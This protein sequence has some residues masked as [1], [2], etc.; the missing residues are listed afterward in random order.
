MDAFCAELVAHPRA[1]HAAMRL[2]GVYRFVVEP[3]GPLADRH[4]YEVS[5]APAAPGVRAH[6]VAGTARPRVTVATDYGRWRRLLEGRL[7]LGTA[8]LFGHL[9]VSGDTTGIMGS[10]GHVDVLVEALREVDT[11]W[12]DHGS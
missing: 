7:D 9:R 12:L 2:H 4:S 3:G 10:R 8:L 6:R 1:P 11:V 5:L